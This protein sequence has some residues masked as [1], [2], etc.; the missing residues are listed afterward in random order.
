[1]LRCVGSKVCLGLKKIK[2]LKEILRQAQL[3]YMNSV[4]V[5]QLDSDYHLD[6]FNTLHGI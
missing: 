2:A 6:H 3:P 4:I 5:L 1:M